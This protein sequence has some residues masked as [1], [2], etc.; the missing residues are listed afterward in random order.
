MSLACPGVFGGRLLCVSDS[1][2]VIAFARRIAASLCWVLVVV[3]VLAPATPARALGGDELWL[4]T[5][6][7]G[8][9]LFSRFGHNA[10]LTSFA[11]VPICSSRKSGLRLAA[12][13]RLSMCAPKWVG[14][15]LPPKLDPG[16]TVPSGG[17]VA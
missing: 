3:G 15:P 10:L 9:D 6:A 12:T 7:P 11:V 1:S 8:D 17:G 14:S 4:I 13:T 16:A 5:M 2:V